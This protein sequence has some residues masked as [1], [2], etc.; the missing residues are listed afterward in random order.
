MFLSTILYIFYIC[1]DSVKIC[2]RCR[3][4]YIEISSIN[5]NGYKE[6]PKALYCGTTTPPVYISTHSKLEVVFHSDV[7]TNAKGF[8]GH[9]EFLDKSKYYPGDKI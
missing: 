7:T 9:Y 8:L 1:I 4:D 3:Y 5:A 6:Q 2:S